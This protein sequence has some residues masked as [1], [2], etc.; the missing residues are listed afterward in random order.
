MHLSSSQVTS[1][2]KGEEEAGR[3]GRRKGKPYI[4]DSEGNIESKRS[5]KGE[6]KRWKYLK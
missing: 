3:D 6:E 2:W 4:D 1:D 5:S